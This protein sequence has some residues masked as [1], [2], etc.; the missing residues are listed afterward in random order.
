LS[1]SDSE[2]DEVAKADD[3]YISNENT[4]SGL[5]L[6][7]RHV[8]LTSRKRKMGQKISED[9]QSQNSS[10]I[11]T[12]LDDDAPRSKTTRK[13]P[14]ASRSINGLDETEQEIIPL[15]YDKLKTAL[16]NLLPWPDTDETPNKLQTEADEMAAD[17]WD[18][19]CVAL[20]VSVDPSCK[21]LKMVCFI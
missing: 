10:P 18:D 1:N 9:P 6:T 19:S 15:A 4:S 8:E 2:Q 12:D 21:A 3:E 5:T 16:T 17:A 14:R 7:R 11:D 20:K 13:K